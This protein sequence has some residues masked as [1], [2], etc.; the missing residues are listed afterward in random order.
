MNL[1]DSALLI[2]KK[3]TSSK[4]TWQEHLVELNLY[5]FTD[6]PPPNIYDVLRGIGVDE[7]VIELLQIH[8]ATIK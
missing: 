1:E 4:G 3:L 5:P 8:E 2:Y 6:D 7:D